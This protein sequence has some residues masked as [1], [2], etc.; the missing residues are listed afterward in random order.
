[1]RSHILPT[2]GQEDA[3]GVI[4]FLHDLVIDGALRHSGKQ[5]AQDLFACRRVPGFADLREQGSSLR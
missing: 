1:M 3:A 4:R 2:T 5:L